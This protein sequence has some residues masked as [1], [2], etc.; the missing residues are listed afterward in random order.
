MS[1]QRMT[2]EI[3]RK[4]LSWIRGTIISIPVLALGFLLTSGRWDW[5]WGWIFIA[6]LSLALAAHVA[7]LLPINP[8]LLA[9]RSEGTR[10]IGTKPWDRPLVFTAS[11]FYFGS[12]IV[13]GLDIRWGWTGSVRLSV[14][15][16]GVVL[17][18]LGWTIFLWAMACNPFFSESVR[19]QPGHQVAAS[20]PYRW[21]RHPGY[22]GA[23]FQLFS[24]PLVLGSWWALIPIAPALAAYVLRT[25]LEDRTL[26]DE[27]P[28]YAD[29]AHHVPY[30]LIP[31]IW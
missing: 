28:G 15:L 7:V 29:Y 14:H 27:L 8:A 16:L 6:L 12:M 1:I 22:V 20:G 2:P 23:F 10:Q 19:I 30:R 18:L 31:G 13:S 25:A 26:Q 24:T 11:I 4:V 9:D 3:K 5:S 21:V 17:Y